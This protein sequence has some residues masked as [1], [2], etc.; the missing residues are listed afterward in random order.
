[1]VR[2]AKKR[3]PLTANGLFFPLKRYKIEPRP[4]PGGTLRGIYVER[5]LEEYNRYKARSAKGNQGN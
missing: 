4:N 2:D 5:I 3:K 1:M